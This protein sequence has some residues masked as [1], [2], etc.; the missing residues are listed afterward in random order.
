VKWLVFS[1]PRRDIETRLQ[2]SGGRADLQLE[3][4][5]DYVSHGVDAYIDHKMSELLAQYKETYADRDPKVL[6][7][8]HKVENEVAKELRRKADGPCLQA[9][10]RGGM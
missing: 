7:E 9:N 6:E 4:N 8:L 10:Q 1:R 2:K 5:A 3:H